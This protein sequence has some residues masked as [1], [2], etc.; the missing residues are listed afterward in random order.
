MALMIPA[1]P[2]TRTETNVTAPVLNGWGTSITTGGSSSTK[3]TAVQ[4]IAS[5]AFD[6]WWVTVMASAHGNIATASDA[7]LDILVGAATEQVLIPNLLAGYSGTSGGGGPRVWNFPL[8][9]PAGSRIAARA[10]GLRTSST[11]RVAIYL[12]GGSGP[13]PFKCATRIDTVG[14]GT[15]PNG[16]AVTPGASGAEGSWTE[17]VASTT[18]DA[19]GVV[20]SFQV[21]NDTTISQRA[22][23]LDI[24]VGS[25]TEEEI[26]GPYNYASHAGELVY[27][28]V[29]YPT[30][31]DIPASSRLVV[32]ASNS[33]TNDAGYDCALHLLVA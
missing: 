19:F 20:P 18:R 16:T 29:I 32:R 30:L 4:L 15:V 6:T 2:F 17:I 12:Y 8:Y 22:Y 21:T 28:G 9:I 10:A 27:D 7:C 11:M 26:G 24:G 33:N 25:A 23:S 13:P 1:Y 14:I 3:G 31:V 5:T